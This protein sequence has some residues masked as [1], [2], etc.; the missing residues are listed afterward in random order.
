M[1]MSA[2]VFITHGTKQ[3]QV[4]G[5]IKWKGL[6]SSKKETK[7]KSTQIYYESQRGKKEKLKEINIFSY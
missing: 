3:V 5:L 1:F 6:F 4:D 2:S 7:A